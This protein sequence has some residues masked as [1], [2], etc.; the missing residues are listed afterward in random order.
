MKMFA[1]I[2]QQRADH[3]AAQA[4]CLFQDRVEHRRQIARRGIDHP[5]HFGRRGLALQRVALFGQQPGVLDRDHRLHGKVLQ[6][7]DLLLGESAHL[8]AERT[9]VAQQVAIAAQRNQQC[10][11]DLGSLG[12]IPRHRVV[13]GNIDG[14]HVKNMVQP[15]AFDQR[16]GQHRWCKGSAR[17]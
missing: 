12:K 11:P 14:S 9:D 10:R 2:D 16:L 13:L 15:R 3:G 7:C 8:V 6:Q 5:Q 4:V 17:Q 1:V